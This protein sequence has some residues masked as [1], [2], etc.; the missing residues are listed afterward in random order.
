LQDFQQKHFFSLQRK[1]LTGNL[2]LNISSQCL[3]QQQQIVQNEN[4]IKNTFFFLQN[5]AIFVFK[6]PETFSP[7]KNID[8]KIK[9]SSGKKIVHT[10]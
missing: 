5:R 2:F 9:I 6:M 7:N 3:K 10:I 4:V 8:R 1:G